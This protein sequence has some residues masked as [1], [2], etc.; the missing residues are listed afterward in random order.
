MPAVSRRSFTESSCALYC[1]V[2]E[3][4]HRFFA[5]R[6]LI[7]FIK[8]KICTSY[9]EL[10]QNESCNELHYQPPVSLP[11]EECFNR[12]VAENEDLNTNN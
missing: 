9:I 11:A 12:Y 8:L 1:I 5:S 4:L 10:L 3:H 7:D 6:R 2:S